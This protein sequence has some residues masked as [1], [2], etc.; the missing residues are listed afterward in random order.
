MTIVNT[1]DR[2]VVSVTATDSGDWQVVSVPT[3]F[4]GIVA[5]LFAENDFLHGFVRHEDGEQWEVYDFDGGDDTKLLQVTSITG[6][7]TLARPATPYDSSRSDGARMDA[8]S[9][10]HTMALS[11]GAGT[12]K[13]LLRETSPF[14]KTFASADATPSV[15]GYR[16]FKTN[17]TTAITRFDDLTNGQFFWVRRGNADIV[18]THDGTNIDLFGSANVTLTA[19]SPVACFAVE[20]GRA[21][22]MSGFISPLDEDDFASNSSTRP[23]SQQSTKAY[24]ASQILDEDDFASNS[25]AKAPSQQSV[26][27]YLDGVVADAIAELEPEM[28]AR[29]LENTVLVSDFGIYP[30]DHPDYVS[31]AH[32]TAQIDIAQ[33][34]ILTT[35]GRGAL[36]FGAST[37]VHPYLFDAST[38]TEIF[39][40]DG[41]P[42]AATTSCILL[43][44]GISLAAHPGRTWLKASNATLILICMISP[45]DQ[46]IVG[47]GLDGGF[48]TTNAGHG[49]LQTTLGDY[50]MTNIAA[51]GTFASSDESYVVTGT[52][53]KSVE[54]VGSAKH[55]RLTANVGTTT[56]PVLGKGFA[57]TIGR[58]YR[59]RAWGFAG[60]ADNI[61]MIVTNSLGSGGTP[62]ATIDYAQD[63]SEAANFVA[64]ATT[65]YIQFYCPTMTAGEY[66]EFTDVYMVDWPVEDQHSYC[67]NVSIVDNIIQ[68]FGSY[69]IGIQSG[70]VSG[71]RIW[72]NNIENTG[73]DGMDI[74]ARGL[75]GFPETFY[76]P[77]FSVIGNYV[78]KFGQRTSLANQAGID[79]RGQCYCAGNYVDI[80]NASVGTSRTGIRAR[81]GDASLVGG[82]YTRIEGNYIQADGLDNSYGVTP[83]AHHCVALGNI[84]V[85]CNRGVIVEG[86]GT[87]DYITH[88]VLISN[89][90]FIACGTGVLTNSSSVRT[91]IVGNIGKDIV[92]GFL[93]LSGALDVARN[94]DVY[95]AGTYAIITGDDIVVDGGLAAGTIG[96]K[97]SKTGSGG[98]VRNIDGI[99][100]RYRNKSSFAAD[101]TG[102]ITKSFSPALDVTPAI[103]DCVVSYQSSDSAC[104]IDVKITSVSASTI[105]TIC[106]VI[107][108]GAASSTANVILNVNTDKLT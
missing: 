20:A 75:R 50:A 105:S 76:I 81:Q 71:V 25:A 72:R 23:P 58:N 8:G 66:I 43:R 6:T 64:T 13:Q 2:V 103:E 40:N 46:S 108:A 102:G 36:Q 12:L 63:I 32:N 51:P 38:S 33:Q 101:A 100:T 7:V 22:Q 84:I 87:P 9:G 34:Y 26:K 78:K 107:T 55:L 53:T 98:A 77:A 49:I 3:G 91:K 47:F 61:E 48:T 54:T 93:N 45:N 59:V 57:T 4:Q 99:K 89:N 52:G 44:E 31:A 80:V 106:R 29:H 62:L 74:K 69:G 24:I 96:T 10:T 28:I 82:A 95:T 73:A 56:P 19:A 88:D 27:A 21:R 14:W 39:D 94:N 97:I 16:F 30:T 85:G 68:N 92:Y 18:I 83:L 70:E 86:T 35:F 79:I 60:T 65:T 15:S 104:V 37:E 67:K 17:G 1:A 42:M 11:I 5:T 90:Q 41:T